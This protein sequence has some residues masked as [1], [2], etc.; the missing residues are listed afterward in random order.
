MTLQTQS[1]QL[2][3]SHEMNR[4][5]SGKWVNNALGSIAK[6]C[7]KVTVGG[8]SIAHKHLSKRQGAWPRLADSTRNDKRKKSGKVFVS[9]G[10][11]AKSIVKRPVE[12]KLNGWGRG[13]KRRLRYS[14]NGLFSAAGINKD[15]FWMMTGFSGKLK[16]SKGF[17]RKRRVLAIN[18]GVNLN[19]LKASGQKK[20]IRRAVSVSET[21]KALKGSGITKFAK[22]GKN[23]LAYADVVQAGSF[24]S[25][26]KAPR[27][28]LPYDSS[29]V[30]K[31]Q[32]AMERGMANT[33]KGEFA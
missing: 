17:E 32:Q 28:L 20:A 6:E 8:G 3:Y 24:E 12:G 26:K 13:E 22:P 33:L 5:L 18:K 9:N 15:G 29:D 31:L 19:G 14:A 27:P 1:V 2:V 30:A 10:T 21:S 16:N 4:L 11:V 7:L 25:D 23:N